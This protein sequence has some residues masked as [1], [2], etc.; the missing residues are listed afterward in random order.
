MQ[1]R[2]QDFYRVPKVSSKPEPAHVQVIKQ[3]VTETCGTFGS[4]E[5]E[6]K[7]VIFH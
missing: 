1:W 7:F 6:Q 4:A 3:H 2:S 5:I